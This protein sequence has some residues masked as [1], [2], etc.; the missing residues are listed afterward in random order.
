MIDIETLL[1]AYLQSI[2]VQI[3]YPNISDV[4]E[5]DFIKIRMSGIGASEASMLL[6]V[7][8]FP[9][10]STEDLINNKVTGAFDA[11]ISLKSSVRKGK[12]LEDFIQ[13]KLMDLFFE[14]MYLYKPRHMYNIQETPLNINFDSIL[15]NHKNEVQTIVE[16]KL[17]TRFGKRYYDFS[18]AL[19]HTIAGTP[20]TPR[21]ELEDFESK[22]IKNI[23]EF[24]EQAANYYGIPVYYYTQV[25]QQ[26]M[27]VNKDYGY[28]GVLND[29][30]WEFYIFKVHSAP[31]VQ[32]ALRNKSKSIWTKIL[33]KREM[34]ENLEE[35]GEDI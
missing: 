7:N 2:G 33:T 22:G 32:N 8:P 25:Q 12:D 23:K 28:L 34:A 24:C 3:A 10:S 5:E 15:M 11:S 1:A 18:K 30:D 9:N 35:E 16:I 13:H 4:L 21:K 31:I 14:D 6:E 26:L 20:A 17:V 29:E 27:A 19:Y